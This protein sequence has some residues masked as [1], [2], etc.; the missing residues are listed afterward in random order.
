M[1]LKSTWQNSIQV[2]LHQL[3]LLLTTARIKSATKVS[4][5]ECPRL[6]T[7]ALTQ[8]AFVTD[9]IRATFS[10]GTSPTAAQ[11]TLSA[12]VAARWSAFA[13]NGSPNAQGYVNWNAVSSGL[14]LNMLTLDGA[15][16]KVVQQ[17]RAPQCGPNGFWGRK[18]QYD[19]TIF[20]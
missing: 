10:T 20:S 5:S 14:Q 8:S 9:D 18:A 3:R 11:N 17:Q 19:E 15:G 6:I 2:F 1:L 4:K 13:S 12:E 7:Q 16:S